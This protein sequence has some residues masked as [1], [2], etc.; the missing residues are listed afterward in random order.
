M[1]LKLH[2]GRGLIPLIGACGL[3]LGAGCCSSHERASTINQ[4][5]ASVGFQRVPALPPG[6]TPPKG[7]PADVAFRRGLRCIGTEPD[8][9]STA[10]RMSFYRIQ[11][12][13]YLKLQGYP[14]VPMGGLWVQIRDDGSA[15]SGTGF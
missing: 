6:S 15:E 7:L 4:P 5:P 11:D 13:W 10:G 1:K 3:L 12:G 14:G 8:L 9:F 2:I